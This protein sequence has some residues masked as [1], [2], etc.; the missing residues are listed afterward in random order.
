MNPPASP[1][2][3][4]AKFSLTL[5]FVVMAMIA[6]FTFVSIIFL[7]TGNLTQLESSAA[8]NMVYTL[9]SVCG[10]GMALVG[11]LA[12]AYALFKRY[13]S[14]LQAALGVALNWEAWFCFFPPRWRY[15]LIALPGC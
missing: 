4:L 14:G 8:P 6:L 3:T 10:E 12:G 2:A 13:P 9:L 5:G 11:L 1:S 15:C 7:L